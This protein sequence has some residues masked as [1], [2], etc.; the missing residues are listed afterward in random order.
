ML[1]LNGLLPEQIRDKQPIRIFGDAITPDNLAEI[2]RKVG[3]LFQ[4]A[5]DQL[6]CPTVYEDVAFGPRQQLLQEQEVSERVTAAIRRVGLE[7]S[8]EPAAA[9]SLRRAKAPGL[10]GRRAGVRSADPGPR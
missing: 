5:N 7:G 8:G 2:R 10:P 1:H 4:D 3:L 9:P 6:F